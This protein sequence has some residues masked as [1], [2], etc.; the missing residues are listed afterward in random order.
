M[1]AERYE[2]VDDPAEADFAFLYID[3]P[4]GG[5]GYNVEDRE[6]GG[7]GY[8][9]ISL[10]YGEYTADHARAESIA[11]GDPMEPSANRSYRGKTVISS[12]AS[13]MDLVR[14]ARRLIGDKPL[15]LAVS[16]LKPFVP[17]EIEPYADALILAIEVQNQAVLDIVSGAFEPQG[18]L[19]VQLPA[20]MKA[21]EEQYEDKA[22]D[23]RCYVDADGN[24]YDFAFGMNWSGVINDDR[25]KKYSY[26]YRK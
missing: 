13:D 5:E 3:E 26:I 15:V 20:D 22:H 4:K 9:P 18:L 2:L 19:P 21:V 25:V 1:M 11:G 17:A 24:T 10:Q 7:N 8:M 23:M 14:E 16:M 6:N 12:N